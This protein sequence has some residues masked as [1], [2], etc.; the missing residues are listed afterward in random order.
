MLYFSEN[1][2]F[3]H[4]DSARFE[5]LPGCVKNKSPLSRPDTYFTSY[6]CSACIPR[7]IVG[8]KNLGA[9]PINK[10]SHLLK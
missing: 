9:R 7:M 6:C 8:R 2:E 1:Y 5:I 4:H 3:A 10:Q